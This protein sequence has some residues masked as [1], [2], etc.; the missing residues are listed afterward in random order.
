MVP[1]GAV[2][3]PRWRGEPVTV[4]QRVAEHTGV[5]VD[6]LR[7]PGRYRAVVGARRIALLVWRRHLGRTQGEMA[8]ALGLS[9][10]AVSQLL[11]Q[12]PRA[13]EE[14]HAACIA[15]RCWADNAE[16]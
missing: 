1:E 12:R 9:A 2:I 5:S 8:D 13:E 4:L 15:G 16:N 10:S 7:A 3:R 6:T 11:N 14:A